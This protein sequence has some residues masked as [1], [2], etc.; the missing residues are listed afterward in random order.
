MLRPLILPFPAPQR[1]PLLDDGQIRK[2]S[3]RTLKAD[4]QDFL[5][6]AIV[7]V[8]GATPTAFA[9]YARS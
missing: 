3:A 2:P 9:A 6:I 5:V 7:V 4:R 1:L 8:T